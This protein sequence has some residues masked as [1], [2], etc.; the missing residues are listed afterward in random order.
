MTA[1]LTRE[2]PGVTSGYKPEAPRAIEDEEKEFQAFKALREARAEKRH[3]GA[4]KKREAAKQA[5]ENA[6]K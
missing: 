3:E 6:K 2:M 1:H 4:R 5:E